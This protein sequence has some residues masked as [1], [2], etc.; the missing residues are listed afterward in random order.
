MRNL[1]KAIRVAEEAGGDLLAK[2]VIQGGFVGNNIVSQSVALDKFKDKEMVPSWNLDA[3]LQDT[4]RILRS[5]RCLQIR[6]V[7]SFAPRLLP[8]CVIV[9]FHRRYPRTCVTV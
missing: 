8:Q 7:C 4:L 6:L 5:P 1:G 2:V 3:A 9:T